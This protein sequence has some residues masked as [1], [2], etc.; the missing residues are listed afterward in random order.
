MACL[1]TSRPVTAIGP[2]LGTDAGANFWV[3]APTVASSCEAE[4][5]IAVAPKHQLRKLPCDARTWRGGVIFRLAYKN[6][7][8]HP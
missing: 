3:S 4:G 6:A 5:D 8:Q 2:L 1:A 7:P